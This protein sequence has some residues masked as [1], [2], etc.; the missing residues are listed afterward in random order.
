M[1]VGSDRCLD[2][3]LCYW[4]EIVTRSCMELEG[5]LGLKQTEKCDVTSVQQ[6]RG[7]VFSDG[8]LETIVC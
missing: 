6:K 3:P 8:V 1:G 7:T 5:T 4:N 2:V